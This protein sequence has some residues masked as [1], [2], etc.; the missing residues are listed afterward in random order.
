MS[1]PT[2]V[3]V[4]RDVLVRAARAFFYVSAFFLPLTAVRSVGG[5]TVGDGFL[6]G[7]T[8]LC[9]FSLARP[10][11]RVPRPVQVATA[12]SALA[13]VALMPASPAPLDELAV[14]IRLCVVWLVWVWVASVV[15]RSRAH[16]VAAAT[17]FIAGSALSSVVAVGQLVGVDLRPYLLA[18]PDEGITARFIGLGGHPNGQ[19]GCLGVAMV[20]C[21]AAALVGYRRVWALLLTIVVA[22][23]LLLT[24][25]ITGILTV[26][27]GFLILLWRLRSP[28]VALG[29]GIGVGAGVGALMLLQR[30]FPTVVTPFD[31][32]ESA[33]GIGGVSTVDS[34][35]A[36]LRF[37]RDHIVAN[38]L[39]GT[40]FAGGGGT[41]NGITQAHNM[42]VLAWYQG[43]ILMVAAVLVMVITVLVAGLRSKGVMATTAFAATVAA[44]FFAQTG[45]SLYD[46]FIWFPAVLLFVAAAVERGE[47]RTS[48]AERLAVGG[49]ATRA[50][51]GVPRRAKGI[52]WG[53]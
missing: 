24:A 18:A 22:V 48:P 10:P 32:F 19:G 17:A 36:T 3:D 43:G 31:R 13:A 37:A 1:V 15:L 47:E 7:A 2:P 51:A 21:L 34:R 4:N 39:R 52:S 45:P 5:F 53:H 20:F 16:L 12:L 9:L 28:R 6:A 50:L 14:G 26:A 11:G 35:I 41:Y 27:V 29:A 42:E 40:G 30:S 23:G 25:S 33:V 8:L 49:G 46:R 44:L 38:P